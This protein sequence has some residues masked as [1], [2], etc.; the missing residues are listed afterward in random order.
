MTTITTVN[1]P[2]PR[3]RD[4]NFTE[5]IYIYTQHASYPRDII[6]ERIPSESL[7]AD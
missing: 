6:S 7:V 5:V 4:W 3:S 1:S 2:L